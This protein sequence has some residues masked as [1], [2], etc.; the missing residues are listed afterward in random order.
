MQ[1]PFMG[2]PMGLPHQQ[3]MG[4]FQQHPYGF[5]PRGGPFG[6]PLIPPHLQQNMHVQ[7]QNF[8]LDNPHQRPPIV[9]ESNSKKPKLNDDESEFNLV[10]ERDWLQQHTVFCLHIPHTLFISLILYSFN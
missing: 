10:P 1:S 3:P 2:G 9:N 6:Q 7:P 5:P 4:A 8:V